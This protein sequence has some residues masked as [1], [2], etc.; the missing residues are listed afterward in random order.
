[1]ADWRYAARGFDITYETPKSENVK[2]FNLGE[3][4]YDHVVFLP[5]KVKGTKQLHALYM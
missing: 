2:L 4:N 1:M 3:R 5:T